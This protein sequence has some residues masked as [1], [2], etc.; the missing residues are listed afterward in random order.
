MTW[1]HTLKTRWNQ[2]ALR[3]QR[4]L[5]VAAAL[6][7]VVLVWSILLAPALRTLKAAPAQNTMLS[8]EMERMQ[9]LQTRARQLQTK[10]ALSPKESLKALQA[11]TAELGKSATLQVVGDQAT[12]TVKQLS[13]SSLAPWLSPGSGV[14]LSPTDVQ[15]QRSTGATEPLWSGTLVFSLPAGANS[16]P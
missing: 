14:G 8:T 10:P 11:A 16:T 2:L 1:Q 12:L 7:A 9:A 5:V 3:E 13:A 6:L 4:L 15:L